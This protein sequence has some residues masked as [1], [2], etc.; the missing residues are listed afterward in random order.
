MIDNYIANRPL[1]LLNKL[2]LPSFEQQLLKAD[3]FP[4]KSEG[5]DIMQVNLGKMCNQTCNHCHVD[6]GP[7]RREIMSQETMMEC[8]A[9]VDMA[10]IGTVDLTGG[11]PEMN[12]N[13]RWFV[14]ELS[15]R[16]IHIIVR[17]NL[18][19]VLANPKYHDLPEF[20]R[21]HKIEVISSLPHYSKLRTDAQRGDGVY[22]KSI[23]VLKMLNRQQ[24]GIEGSG[25]WLNLVFNPSGAILPPEQ[26]SLERDYKTRLE[27]AHGILFN[28]L[29]T[30]TNMPISRFL[31]YLVNSGNLQQYMDELISRFNPTTIPGLMCRS[32]I[33]VG[34]DGQLYDCDFNQMLE[35]NSNKVDHIRSFDNESLKE[36]EL[37]TAMHCYGCTAGNGSSCGGEIS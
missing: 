34:W 19:I 31:D 12:P 32:M 27:S 17:S 23:E 4:L 15:S 3:Y 26:H 1:A 13:F 29:Y 25:L 6:A 35:I 28:N 8:L 30:I 14:A 37:K 20:F 36:R 33:S 22:D 9:A 24:F 11:A 16:N 21:K 10:K 5:I 7:H 18:T 2:D